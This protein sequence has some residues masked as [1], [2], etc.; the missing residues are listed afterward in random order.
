[1]ILYVWIDN[2]R[3]LKNIGFNLTSKYKFEFE[4]SIKNRITTGSL[5][6]EKVSTYNI[7]DG[8]LED[9][10]VI[11]GK[12]GT[13][14]ST[15]IF[16]L[17]ESI[18]SDYA[19]AFTGFIVT[20]KYIFN[21]KGIVINQEIEI[22]G[23]KLTEI[24]NA[25]ISNFW[26][27]DMDNKLTEEQARG[28]KGSA[29]I[30][31]YLADHSFFYYSPLIN[32]DR[33]YEGETAIAGNGIYEV[34]YNKFFDLSTEAQAVND[35]SSFAPF[36]YLELKSESEILCHKSRESER[37]LEY[38]LEEKNTLPFKITIP[39]V[40]VHLNQ[41]SINYWELISRQF[42]SDD[43]LFP[44]LTSIITKIESRSRK[45]KL[46]KWT[47]FED[48]LVKRILFFLLRYE[49]NHRYNFG[50]YG[51]GN[52]LTHT[53]SFFEKISGR[54]KSLRGLLKNYLSSSEIYKTDFK[55]LFK[56]IETF[57]SFL[58]NLSKKNILKTSTYSIE[59]DSK[60]KNIL[61]QILKF[62]E[63][64]HGFTRRFEKTE[65]IKIPLPVFSYEFHGLSAGEKSFLHLLSRFHHSFKK[66]NPDTKEIIVF[67]DEPEIAFHPQW[68]K[69][70]IKVICNF[71]KNEAAKY[72][73]QLI[74]TGHSPIIISDFPNQNI[75]FLNKEDST[76]IPFISKLANIDNTFA[77]NIHS[78]YADA[79]FIQ[80]G[81]IG[82]FA[83]DKIEEAIQ[84]IKNK[85][86]NR[87]EVAWN[88]L[89]LIGDDLIKERM[90]DYFIESFDKKQETLDEEI[91]RLEQALELA[92]SK[93][94]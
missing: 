59:I 35:S 23:G 46:P 47:H 36:E 13:G 12:N 40:Q 2:Y 56:Q 3:N 58:H 53:I 6:C 1:M 62:S 94:K 38:I 22:D 26:R 74:I 85:D 37:V 77:A 17:L 20:D 54:Q 78:L 21:R 5:S 93:K 89:N 84:I 42:K 55:D 81:T 24:K 18:L 10:K 82:E 57:L 39:G 4:Y 65:K 88:I 67:L 79:F 19:R 29:I 69:E 61:Q 49:V 87:K 71:F 80:N 9:I 28:H 8:Y 7:F 44:P 90:K 25:E 63:S 68:Q 92:K 75:I 60:E 48:E 32:Y 34:D 45:K 50:D 41:F 66:V 15:M 91:I 72:K 31:T 70:F 16:S 27:G 73:F 30:D 86:I 51:K 14:K 83:K 52:A 64:F 76:N 33:V 43:S 11:I